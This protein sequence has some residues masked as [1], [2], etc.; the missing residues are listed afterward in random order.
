MSDDDDLFA[1]Y[2]PSPTL[3]GDSFGV[4]SHHLRIGAGAGMTFVLRSSDLANLKNLDS[5]FSESEYGI[6]GG[7]RL[8]RWQG[9]AINFSLQS[10]RS[11]PV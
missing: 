8:R 6:N 7:A 2:F 9:T 10:S 1:S 5:E 3:F 4:P 11:P